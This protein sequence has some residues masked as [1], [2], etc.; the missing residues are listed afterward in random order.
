MHDQ[1]RLAAR[2]QVGANLPD[3][4]GPTGKKLGVGGADFHFLPLEL[5]IVMIAIGIATGCGWAM[6]W[7][8]SAALRLSRLQRRR[9]VWLHATSWLVGWFIAGIAVL[10]V[11]IIVIVGTDVYIGQGARLLVGWVTMWTIIAGGTGLP[12][13]HLTSGQND[14]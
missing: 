11:W 4:P 3:F 10:A 14:A 1:R 6:S 13:R 12:V 7:C 8:Y 9:W 5:L 2:S